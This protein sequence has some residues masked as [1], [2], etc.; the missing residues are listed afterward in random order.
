M[1]ENQQ[2]STTISA[3]YPLCFLGHGI[4]VSLCFVEAMVVNCLVTMSGDQMMIADNQNVALVGWAEDA[5]TK[6]IGYW[7]PAPFLETGSNASAHSKIAF[8]GRSSA[9]PAPLH[10]NV[11]SIFNISLPMHY[12]YLNIDNQVLYTRS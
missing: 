11:F 7:Y 10:S 1:V 2:A 12:S 9:L 3:S 6:L 4:H 5:G 8:A